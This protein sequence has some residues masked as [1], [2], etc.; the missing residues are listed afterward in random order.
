MCDER[1]A[2]VTDQPLLSFH[3]RR[4]G[5]SAAGAAAST[6][7]AVAFPSI[8]LYTHLQREMDVKA[9]K[10]PQGQSGREEGAAE[11]VK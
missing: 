3:V 7:K 4:P 2:A 6:G 1:P 10:T 5:R 9:P 11:I 8:A